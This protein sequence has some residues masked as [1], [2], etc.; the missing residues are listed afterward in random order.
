MSKNKLDITKSVMA[1]IDKGQVKMKPKWM[2]IVGTLALIGGVVGTYLLSVFLISLISFSL[3]THGPMGE[4]RYQELLSSFPLWSVG[5][6]I[7]GLVLG[8]I[9]LKRFDFSYKKNFLF[10]ILAFI[11]TVLI[12]G[13][14][15]DYLGLDRVWSKQR[16][17][18]WFYQQYD[19]GKGK[20]LPWRSDD[21][22]STVHKYEQERK[23]VYNGY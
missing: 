19:G 8:I 3:R 1:K 13:W 21:N 17:M 22:I 11:V 9:L 18:R 4:V 5:L 12:S 16:E 20:V 15:V 6:A 7:V 23:R 10:I 2:F 14:L